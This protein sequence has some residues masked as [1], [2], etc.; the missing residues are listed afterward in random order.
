ML[1][2]LDF[3]KIFWRKETNAEEFRKLGFKKSFSFTYTFPHSRSPAR[4]RSRSIA[5]SPFLSEES[6]YI[7]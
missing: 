3:K 1:N 7:F 2:L 6:P 5:S 4:R